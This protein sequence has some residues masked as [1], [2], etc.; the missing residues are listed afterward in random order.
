MRENLFSGDCAYCG[1]RVPKF[2][3]KHWYGAEGTC[4]AHNG[5]LTGDEVEAEPPPRD[6]RKKGKM[7]GPRGVLVADHG[8]NSRGGKVRAKGN[9]EYYECLHCGHKQR[10]V[11]A[12][13]RRA[14]RVRCTNCSALVQPMTAHRT[15]GKNAKAKGAQK[16]KCKYN[17]CETLLRSNHNIDYCNDCFNRMSLVQRTAVLNGKA[18]RG[19]LP[20]ARSDDA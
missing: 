10:E 14:T 13:R 16:R 4:V 6:P 20:K 12:A 2:G 15:K 8:G 5:C 17:K 7:P 11:K 9:I 3:G 19:A 18:M 1:R